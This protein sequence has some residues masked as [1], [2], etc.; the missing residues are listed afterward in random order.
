MSNM[1]LLVG[2]NKY[3]DGNNLRGCCNDVDNVYSILVDTLKTFK[4]NEIVVLK[5][6]QATQE[7]IVG[8]LKE[9]VTKLNYKSQGFFSMSGHGSQVA[10]KDGDEADHKDELICPHDMNWDKKTYI[11]D[12]DL[13][14]IFSEIPDGAWLEVLLDCCHSGTATRSIPGEL[15]LPKTV[16]SP[17]ADR[18]LPVRR[19]VRSVEQVGNH[20][21]WAGCEDGQYSADAFINGDYNGACTYFWARR[22]RR[23]PEVLRH[24]LLQGV[25]VDL[26]KFGFDQVPQLTVNYSQE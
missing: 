14:E 23:N 10:D 13:A 9:M 18:D 17:Y 5:N 16:A 12:D 8:Y 1:A 3:E 19:M 11:T 24:K 21:L 2:I 6:E 25:R 22:L 7:A 26:V 20:V 15:S 4:P